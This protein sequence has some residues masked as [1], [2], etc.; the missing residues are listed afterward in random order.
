MFEKYMKAAT[1]ITHTLLRGGPRQALIMARAVRL[2]LQVPPSRLPTL[3][4]Q[5]ER[6][7]ASPQ[8]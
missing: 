1:L 8:K 3:L 5:L 2:L 4:T 7:Y 6:E